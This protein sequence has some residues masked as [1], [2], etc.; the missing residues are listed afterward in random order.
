[1]K[2]V[3]DLQ[4]LTHDTEGKGQAVDGT[5]TTTWSTTLTSVFVS[6]ISNHC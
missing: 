6:S 2:S 4:K 3:L 5:I 1:M